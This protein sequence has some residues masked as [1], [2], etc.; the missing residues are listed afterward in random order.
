MSFEWQVIKL[1]YLTCVSLTI[2]LFL[3]CQ[4]QG[5]L[6]RSDIQGIFKKKKEKKL[7]HWLQLVN[8]K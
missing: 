2:R 6:P 1:S 4:V 7:E 5:R 8:A 3:W